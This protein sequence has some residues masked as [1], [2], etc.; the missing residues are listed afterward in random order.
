M[1]VWLMTVFS[2]LTALE[3]LAAKLLTAWNTASGTTMQKVAAVITGTPAEQAL[4]A[5]GQE[6]FPKLAATAGPIAAAAMAALQLKHPSAI[7][8][9]QDGLNLIAAEGLITLPKPLVLDG[10]WGPLTKAAF[11]AAETK[12][13]LPPLGAINDAALN[14]LAS[15]LAKVH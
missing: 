14:W 10:L 8:Y 1:P 12:A 13:G 5:I 2:A 7:Q 4:I 6:L 15:E 9:V 3:P 11:E